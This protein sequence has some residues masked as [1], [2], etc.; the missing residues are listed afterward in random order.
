MVASNVVERH[1]SHEKN[2]TDPWHERSVNVRGNQ[3]R[4]TSVNEQ[5]SKAG[6]EVEK[7]SKIE[8]RDAGNE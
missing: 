4:S 5:C 8:E 3:I 1:V 6:P 2:K 7:P